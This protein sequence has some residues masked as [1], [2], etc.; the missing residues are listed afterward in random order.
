MKLLA[1]KKRIP[2]E[3]KLRRVQLGVLVQDKEVCPSGGQLT[4]KTK[5]YACREVSSIGPHVHLPR[6]GSSAQRWD[7]I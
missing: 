1:H 7:K 2:P 5:P 3:N 4:K 6:C